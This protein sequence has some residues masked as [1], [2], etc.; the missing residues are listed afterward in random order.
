MLIVSSSRNLFNSLLSTMAKKI[1]AANFINRIES[2][3][4]FKLLFSVQ[5]SKRC[6]YF[7]EMSD[8]FWKMLANED[9]NICKQQNQAASRK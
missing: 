8:E 3:V 2:V 6:N 5:W 9:H 7:T 1:F 4:Q